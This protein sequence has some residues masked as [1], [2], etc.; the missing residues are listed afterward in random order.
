MQ[1][2]IERNIKT[3]QK[4]TDRW[5]NKHLFCFFIF[6]TPS[7]GFDILLALKPDNTKMISYNGVFVPWFEPQR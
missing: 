6:Y 3:A 4:T 2:Y 5:T 1:N 7:D